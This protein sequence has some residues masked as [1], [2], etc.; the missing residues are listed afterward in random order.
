MPRH[1]N[2]PNHMQKQEL[3]QIGSTRFEI[4]RSHY[5]YETGGVV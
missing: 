3:N 2:A 1:A 4:S 5:F